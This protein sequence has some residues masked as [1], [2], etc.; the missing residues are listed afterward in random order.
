V[1]REIFRTLPAWDVISCRH[2]TLELGKVLTGWQIRSTS[3]AA[4]LVD[5]ECERR[6]YTC[7]LYAFLPRTR[8]VEEVAEPLAMHATV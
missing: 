2:T 5:F 6:S 4:Y 8:I 7:P 3:N 1:K